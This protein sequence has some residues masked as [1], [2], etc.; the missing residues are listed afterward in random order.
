MPLWQASRWQSVRRALGK[1]VTDRVH[2]D[3][4]S[5]V[6]PCR[7]LLSRDGQTGTDWETYPKRQL[8][9]SG[10]ALTQHHTPFDL[11]CLEVGEDRIH[12]ALGAGECGDAAGHW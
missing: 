3:F 2:S 9:C 5:G 7:L 4:G 6:R 8:P 1:S 10:S 12:V 11:S